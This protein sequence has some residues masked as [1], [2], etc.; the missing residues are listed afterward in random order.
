MSLCL[1]SFWIRIGTKIHDSATSRAK[2]RKSSTGVSIA[3]LLSAMK[4][5]RS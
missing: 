3:H 5:T 2:L 1:C 4:N